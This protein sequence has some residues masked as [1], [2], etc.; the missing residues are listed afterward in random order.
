MQ[1][2]IWVGENAKKSQLTRGRPSH[3][4][5]AQTS[6]EKGE[7]REFPIYRGKLV[8]IAVILKVGGNPKEPVFQTGEIVCVH[9]I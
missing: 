3:R 6:G 2:E 7:K 4:I 1:K 5:K 9:K 8:R